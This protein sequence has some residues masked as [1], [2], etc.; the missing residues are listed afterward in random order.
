MRENDAEK[1]RQAVQGRWSEVFWSLA[2]ELG[3][4]LERPG[5]HVHCPV[6]GGKHGDAFRVFRDVSGTGGGICNTCGDYASGW[7]LLMW[8]KGW[9]Y[10]QTL[11]EVGRCLGVYEGA[12]L[13]STRAVRRGAAPAPRQNAIRKSADVREKIN[14]ILRGTVPITERAAKPLWRY[15]L[16]RGIPAGRVARS[17][18]R[19]DRVLRFHPALPYFDQDDETGKPV[20][21][22]YFPALVAIVHDARG[23]AVTVHRTYL[24]RDGLGKADVPGGARKLYPV[25]EDGMLRGGA[26]RLGRTQGCLGIAEGIETALAVALATG[27][28]VWSAINATLLSQWEPPAKTS[29]VVIWADRDRS[30]AGEEYSKRLVRRLHHAGLE[31]RVMLPSGPI[32]AGKSS[33]DW[34]DVWMAQGAE[35]FHQGWWRRILRKAG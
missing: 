7:S 16:A 10:G 5:R 29:S 24:S 8:L 9:S 6:H 32:P 31:V 28:P 22:G 3:P 30:G 2:P 21:V 17:I 25:I 19:H 14:A 33:R 1:V 35:G 15:W 26:I 18:P 11:E 12:P 34:N 4:A 27:E 23:K 20:L 13:T